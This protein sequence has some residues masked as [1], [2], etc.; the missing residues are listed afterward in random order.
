MINRGPVRKQ[1]H[2]LALSAVILFQMACT[3]SRKAE[4]PDDLQGNI[5]PISLF[6]SPSETSPYFVAKAETISQADAKELKSLNIES[7]QRVSINDA[8]VPSE[9]KFM[10]DNLPLVT[11]VQ[12][13]F[14]VTF[15]I[16]LKHI[17]VYKIVDSVVELT[18]FERG[19]TV[20]A[21]EA[22]LISNLSR[23]TEANIASTLVNQLSVQKKA[24]QD[25]LNGKKDGALLVPLFK[26]KIDSYGVVER[27]K[28]ELKEDTSVLKLKETE[29]STATHIKIRANSDA[30]LVIG[31]LPEQIKSL[32][33]IFNQAKLDQKRMFLSE[34]TSV[35]STT[36]PHLEDDTLIYT[37]LDNQSLN[38]YEITEYSKLHRA[39]QLT[40]DIKNNKSEQIISCAATS[41][42]TRIIQPKYSQCVLVR[43]GYLPASFTRIELEQT[44]KNGATSAQLKLS[45]IPKNESVGLIEIKANQEIQDVKYDY[46]IERKLA[47]L[48]N[49]STLDGQKSTIEDLATK[50]KLGLKFLDPKTNVYTR[51]DDD[52]LYIYE[53]TTSSKLTETQLRLFKNNAAQGQIFSCNDESVPEKARS[54]EKDCVMVRVAR[55]PVDYVAI[56]QILL[57]NQDL[58]SDK[59]ITKSVPKN[60]P[61]A[62]VMIAENTAAQQLEVTQS[63]DPDSTIKVSDIQGEFFYRRTF[64]DASNMFLGRTGTSGDMSIVKFELEDDRLVVR[65]QDSLIKYTG[66]G[67]KDKEEIMS[68]PVKYYVLKTENANGVAFVTPQLVETK[69][70]KA[71]YI[72]LDWTD[73]TVPNASSPLAFFDGGDCFM[74]TTSQK[75]TDMDMRLNGPGLLNFSISA[76]YTMK[77]TTQCISVKDVNSAYWAGTYQFNYNVKERIS[78]KRHS[79]PTDD[80]QYSMNISHF[81]QAAFNFGLFTLADRVTETGKQ[82]NV[83]GSEKYMPIVHDFRDN[84]TITYYL[85]GLTTA[86]T[87]P[88]RRKFLF[89]A[90]KQVIAEWNAT[91]AMSFKGTT[92]ER[93][94]IKK[95]PYLKLELDDKNEGHLGDLDRNYIW[96]QELEAENGL[97]GV[98]QPAANPRSGKTMAANVI[99]YTGNTYDQA[100]RLVQVTSLAREYEKTLTAV[101][102][103]ALDELK[104]QKSTPES[105]TGTSPDMTA[106]QAELTVP[107]A[108]KT[109][110]SVN[111]PLIAK[112]QLEKLTNSLY[113]EVLAFGLKNKNVQDLVNGIKVQKL[114]L[115]QSKPLTAAN[116]KSIGK[117]EKV[118]LEN[119][120]STF[121]KNLIALVV[122]KKLSQSPKE[123]ELAVNNAFIQSGGLDQ[124][125]ISRLQAR[126]EQLAMAIRFD[127]SNL[128]RPGCFMYSRE[129]VNDANLIYKKAADGTEVLDFDESV[130]QSFR[131]AVMSTLSHELGHGFGLMHNFKGSTDAE[132]YEFPSAEKT[133]RNYSSIMDYMSDAEMAYKGPGPYDMHAIRAGYTG[134]IELS[135]G[136]LANPQAMNAIATSGIKLIDGKLIHI[137][138]L[139]RLTGSSSFVHITKDTFNSKGLVKYY[140]QCDDGGQ[141]ETVLCATFDYGSTATEI[142]Q[143]KIADYKRAYVTKYYVADKINFNF[144]QK[145]N[146]L[147]RNIGNFQGIRSYLDEAVMA[148]IYGVGRPQAESQLIR[149]DLANAAKLG[150]QFFH[151]LVR[152]PDAN[153]LSASVD[154]LSERVLAA[155]YDYVGD[156]AKDAENTNCTTGDKSQLICSDIKILEAKSLYDVSQ[157]RQKMDSFGIGYDK[158]FAMQFLLQSSSAPTTD[159]SQQSMISYLDF[160]QWFLGITDPADS[161]TVKT[162]K[163]L[164]TGDLKVG[165]FAPSRGLNDTQFIESNQMVEVNRSLGDQ[166]AI[167]SVIGLYESKWKGF[168]LFAEAFKVGRSSASRAPSDRFNVVKLGQS[169]K[170]TDSRVYY[171]T[172]NAVASAAIIKNAARSELLL[173]QTESVFATMKLMFETDQPG[174][175]LL[176]QISDQ[177]I[178]ESCVLDETTQ[179]PQDLAKCMAAIEKPDSE[180]IKENPELAKLRTQGDKIMFRLLKQIRDM[181]ASELILPKAADTS[182]SPVNLAKQVELM[183]SLIN[184][185]LP[186]I[187]DSMQLLGQLPIEK[188]QEAIGSIVEQIDP[189]AKQNKQLEALPLASYTQMFITQYA[190][191]LEV[192]LQNKDKLTG[193]DFAGAMM[194]GSKIKDEHEKNMEIIEKLGLYTGLID[195]DTIAN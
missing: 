162:L 137:N 103:Q 27:S 169:R 44:D 131:R 66:Q 8:E 165:F 102:Q 88:E 190:K 104:K 93:A 128:H 53:I 90:A 19:I 73:N 60:S 99:V 129:D 138:D 42:L 87:S 77:P 55:V 178:N 166:A 95:T 37:R 168:D 153:N 82:Q 120:S 175:K 17:T 122:D 15:S 46:D 35:T 92:L 171:P 151:E 109:K 52:S 173:S 135:A 176:K 117:G 32:D 127:K 96:F 126:S 74:A 164:V 61:D 192:E 1:I 48:H 191:G 43:R 68:I 145:I 177:L 189:I 89:D 62:K 83:D 31:Q 115:N 114:G 195:Q 140:A 18:T 84:K 7:A 94:D 125:T 76:S 188:I 183:R 65:N 144:Q 174:N 159:D 119:N 142:V 26:F 186:F 80:T 154:T 11:H 72:K 132:N 21:R 28:N 75:V 67:A 148:V 79:D 124:A 47:Q 193:A 20:T 14:K 123:L 161:L 185:Q 45:T 160:E 41:E 85:G 134:F 180:Y 147:M 116:L 100:R 158:I 187:I 101:K 6:L 39:E 23:S 13:D 29:W 57:D 146:V 118:H 170:A 113:K 150:Y 152:N 184:Q 111:K 3:K 194:S 64:E 181:N 50:Y 16:D 139:M 36:F 167:A 5:L 172:Q 24:R 141:A 163:D 71:E 33:Q 54:T 106:D 108:Q 30:R 34:L 49:G 157:S 10:F 58:N 105:A 63:L 22:E 86:A 110:S 38:I 51:L 4:L 133:G 112:H 156:P 97:L 149:Q 81:A 70:E 107:L 9:I 155:P 98:A 136:L 78:F 2:I 143:N 59:I 91:F 182:D 25:I 56:E 69:K 121:I 12:R 130:K 179:M 40:Y